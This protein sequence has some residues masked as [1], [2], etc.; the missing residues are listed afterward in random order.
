MKSRRL[1]FGFSNPRFGLLL[2]A[3][4][5][6]LALICILGSWWGRLVL[7]QAGQIE[8][9]QIRTGH[10]AADAHVHWER[11]HHMVYWE[12]SIF[13]ALILLSAA[14][15]FWIYWR[16]MKRARS[17]QAFFASVTHELRTPLTSIRLQAESIAEN[18]SENSSERELVGRLMEDTMRL[19]AQV[20]RTLELARVEG[21]GPVFVQPLQLKPWLERMVQSWREA[22]GSRL[23]IQTSAIDDVTIEADPTCLQTILKN[24]L[25]NSVRHSKRDQTRV[26]FATQASSDGVYLTYQDNGQGY[27]GNPQRLGQL[28]FRGASSQ[29]TGVGLYLVRTLM[30]KM[31]GNADFSQVGQTGFRVSLEFVREV[32]QNG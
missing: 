3:H 21:G 32:S 1:G 2:A 9:L 12:S 11:I 25:E 5:A 18:F 28:F 31:G 17:I 19:E 8:E 26:V 23:E 4:V 24:L 15:I 13:F 16:E 30:R 6:W 14:F 29:G 10:N 7:R 27:G 20:E 22:Y